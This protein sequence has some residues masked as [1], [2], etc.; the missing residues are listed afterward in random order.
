[1]T[2]RM[3]A[4]R[5]PGRGD[6]LENSGLVGRVQTNRE[7]DGL[8]AVRLQ[9]CEHGR[10][11]L[12]PWAVVESEHHLA[13]PQEVVGLEM[14]ETEAGPPCSVDLDDARYADCVRV[15]RAGRGC[16]RGGRLCGSRRLRCGCRRSYRSSCE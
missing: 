4:D 7:E 10:S 3:R 14:L 2:P 16:S 11:I 15:A 6:L 8:G 12:G 1:M 5:M 13:F 9:R